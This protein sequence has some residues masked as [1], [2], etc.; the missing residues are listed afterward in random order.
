MR[1][2]YLEALKKMGCLKLPYY[3]KEDRSNFL[4]VWKK[5]DGPEKISNYYP[6]GLVMDGR[7]IDDEPYKYGYQGQFSEYDSLTKWNAFDLRMYDAR[8]GRFTT[9][10]P[11]KE[12]HSSYLG[13]GNRPHMTT[14]PTGGFTGGTT[15][16]NEVV[17]TASRLPSIASVVGSIAGAVG[18]SLLS[19]AIT[20]GPLDHVHYNTKTQK[21]TVVETDDN[22]D[23]LYV[24]GKR[25]GYSERQAWKHYAPDAEVFGDYS[26]AFYNSAYGSLLRNENVFARLFKNAPS[27]AARGNLF[28]ASIANKDPAIL[29]GTLAL[30]AAPIAA[31]EIIGAAAAFS[32][33]AAFSSKLIGYQSR[34][35]GRFHPKY[36][37]DGVKGLL[38]RGPIRTGWSNKGAQHVFRTAVGKPG[39]RFKIDWF[40][41]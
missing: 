19:N 29:Y 27:Q 18:T 37:P 16:L 14:D 23:E 33:E 17:I 28:K 3:E 7:E 41:K 32:G 35:F 34:L 25:V 15:L 4:G 26:F 1:K 12:F 11:Y 13:M 36:L 8:I 22:Y 30:A 21:T 2:G 5:S 31:G 10:D 38:N 9:T 39:T 24:D 20:A 40:L 6:Y